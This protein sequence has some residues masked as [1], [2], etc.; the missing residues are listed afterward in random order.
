M[1][2]L[3]A[4]K[5]GSVKSKG[6]YVSMVTNENRTCVPVFEN[7]HSYYHDNQFLFGIDGAYEPDKLYLYG[8]RDSTN[9]YY[10][11]F[12]KQHSVRAYCGL[13][14]ADLCESL[15][16]GIFSD[17]AKTQRASLCKLSGDALG[18]IRVTRDTNSTQGRV[19]IT[20]NATS[21]IFESN[22]ITIKNNGK[23]YDLIELLSSINSSSAANDGSTNDETT[24][25]GSTSDGSSH[26]NPDRYDNLVN[27]NFLD[28]N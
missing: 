28:G 11:R 4:G 10:A 3:S 21:M 26:H 13:R 5:Y 24:N 8:P 16:K 19:E 9:S 2:S 6:R 23:T 15:E 14:N 27:D 1:I 12:D 22:T 17:S 18:E 7:T 20:Q 25:D